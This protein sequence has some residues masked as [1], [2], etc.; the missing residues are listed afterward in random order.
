[1]EAAV[2]SVVKFQNGLY[3][4]IQDQKTWLNSRVRRVSNVPMK[5]LSFHLN[6][7]K[8]VTSCSLKVAVNRTGPSQLVLRGLIPRGKVGVSRWIQMF[9]LDPMVELS[10]DSPSGDRDPI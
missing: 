1:M 5:L 2:I 9:R 8:E 4:G 3:S 10:P 6:D 7:T